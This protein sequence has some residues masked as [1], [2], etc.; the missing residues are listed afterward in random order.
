MKLEH[1]C[2]DSAR[3]QLLASCRISVYLCSRLV[4]ITVETYLDERSAGS[5]SLR[6]LKAVAETIGMLLTRHVAHAA[7]LVCF[8]SLFVESQV[9]LWNVVNKPLQLD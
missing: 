7:G 3:K 4:E 5:L 8:K 2:L 1:K 9:R 6:M